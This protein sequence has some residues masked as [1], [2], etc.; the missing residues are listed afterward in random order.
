MTLPTVDFLVVSAVLFAI[1]ALGVV[2][3][4][5][6]LIMFM[7]IELMW[8]AV[9]LTLVAFARQFLAIA[10]HIFVFVVVVVAAAEVAIGLIVIVLV[11]RNR[12]EAD[13][14]SLNTMKG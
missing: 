6:P 1:G 11:F 5:N 9:N 12:S 13:V 10:G 2:I 14:D 8:N 7:A 4:K 3:R